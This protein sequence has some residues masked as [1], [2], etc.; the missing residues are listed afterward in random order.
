MTIT[1]KYQVEGSSELYDTEQA[2]QIAELID[3]VEG[4]YVDK[5]QTRRIAEAFEGKYFLIPVIST[6]TVQEGDPVN[7]NDADFIA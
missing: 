4:I 3:N 5:R 6:V 7:L 2:A 1:Q